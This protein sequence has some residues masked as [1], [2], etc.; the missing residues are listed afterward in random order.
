[1]AKSK[2]PECPAVTII[3]DVH[4]DFFPKVTVHVSGNDGLEA[5]EKLVDVLQGCEKYAALKR[6]LHEAERTLKQEG[7]IEWRG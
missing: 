6:K 4:L 3:G 2:L 7:T 5:V 1:M